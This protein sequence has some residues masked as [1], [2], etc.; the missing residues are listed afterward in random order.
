MAA[1]IGATIMNLSKRQEEIVSFLVSELDGGKKSFSAA[2]INAALETAAERTTL[3][4]DL[5]FLS[6]IFILKAEGSTRSRTYVLD[7]LSAPYLEWDLSRPP[8]MR[9][10]VPYNFN[11]LKEYIPNETSW[12]GK[13]EDMGEF[14]ASGLLTQVENYRRVLNA[15]LID[16][17]YA[18][19]KLEN[20]KISWLDTKSLIEFG[21]QPKG[22][23]RE[24]LAIV[25]NHKDAIKFMCEQKDI[26]SINKRD[27]CDIHKLLMTDLLGNPQDALRQGIVHFDGSK[28]RP[29]DN[30]FILEEQFM[31]FCEKADQINDPLEKSFFSMM[32]ILY[33]QPF[34]D[35]NKRTSR[36]CMN[37]PLL[38]NGLAPFSFTTISKRDY[39]F[40][41]LA[42]Y[43]RGRVEPMREVFK[44]TYKKSSEKY[45]ET[46]RY[47]N[48]GGI[49]STLAIDHKQKL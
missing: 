48:D 43:E 12:L 32:M 15:L 40:A 24:E 38:K 28:Y 34:Q 23:S 18:S 21:E 20:V 9:E 19:S 8:E 4:R 37:L 27:L 31:F 30:P 42:F 35:G 3:F 41:L 47:L 11:I 10:V 39:M 22:L 46:M 25:I 16:L 14:Y 6:S 2:E 7:E 1:T 33:L 49:I 5:S 26:L 17:T 44:Q 13:S 29:I 36:L 45:I